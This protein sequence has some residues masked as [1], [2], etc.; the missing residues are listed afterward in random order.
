MNHSILID[1]DISVDVQVS[2]RFAKVSL[3]GQGY[4]TVSLL[5]ASKQAMLDFANAIVAK[6]AKV[7]EDADAVAV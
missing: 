3:M 2:A 6:V 1:E 4:D 5:F 7:E